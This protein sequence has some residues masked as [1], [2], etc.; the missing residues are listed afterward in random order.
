MGSRTLDEARVLRD[1]E[2]IVNSPAR[3][4]LL[5][6]GYKRQRLQDNQQGQCKSTSPTSSALDLL[7]KARA[8]LRNP[9]GTCPIPLGREEQFQ[10]L[11]SMLSKFLDDGQGLG[12]YVS[13]LPGTGKSH[14]VSSI[15][16][17][18]KQQ[19]GV[20]V[21]SPTYTW[22]NCMSV[23]TS[24]EV[25]QQ[26]SSSISGATAASPL[27]PVCSNAN[28]PTT[29]TMQQLLDQLSKSQSSKRK[30]KQCVRKHVIVL[31]EIDNLMKK[32]SQDVFD[33]FMLP[34]QPNVRILVIGI[35][36]SI[37]LTERALPE[38]KLLG[39]T[40]ELVC[41]PAYTTKQISS[42][43]HKSLES[44]PARQVQHELGY[45]PVFF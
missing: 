3:R 13:G 25:Y 17:S 22:I 31:D 32:G 2:N 45:P 1:V 18:S 29:S 30:S 33:L 43:L 23:A 39:C 5:T 40:P 24:A 19:Q 35:A 4:P 12:T 42:I 15:V 20:Q 7:N 11:Q 37:D 34:H 41:F 6:P 27:A 28:H 8:C 44:L 14:T 9:G 26:I 36:N 38:L 10:R 21:D 16:A